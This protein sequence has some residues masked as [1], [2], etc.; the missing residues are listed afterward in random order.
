MRYY[1][2]I[3]NPHPFVAHYTEDTNAHHLSRIV[4][5]TRLI[6]PVFRSP[7]YQWVYLVFAFSFEVYPRFFSL[8]ELAQMLLVWLCISTLFGIAF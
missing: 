2:L 3:D 6:R 7:F 4:H 5:N 1:P 8:R